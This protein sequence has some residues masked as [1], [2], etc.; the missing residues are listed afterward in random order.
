MG[1]VR[2][3]SIRVP[4]HDRAWDGHVCDDPLANSS[5]LAVKLISEKRRDDVEI[6]IAGEAF[7]GLASGQMPPC[8]R[9]SATFLSPHPHTFESVMAYST[10]SKDHAHIL[11]GPVHVPA[12][13][14]LTIPYR[15]ML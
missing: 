1:V 5:C 7:D 6:A 15:W 10:W 9:A 2:N 14:A 3:L 8:L 11:P 13:G 12:W 4:W